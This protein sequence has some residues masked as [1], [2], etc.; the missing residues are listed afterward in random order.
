MNP[1][2]RHIYTYKIPEALH[3]SSILTRLCS[4]ALIDGSIMRFGKAGCDLVPAAAS[5]SPDDP[6]FLSGTSDD[7]LRTFAAEIRSFHI[8]PSYLHTITHK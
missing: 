4:G 1:S 7:L 8:L 3:S 6:S 2:I 5:G